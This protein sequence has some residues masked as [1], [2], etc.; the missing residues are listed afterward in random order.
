MSSKVRFTNKFFPSPR[1]L[2]HVSD[3]FGMDMPGCGSK[4]TR[5]DALHRHQKGICPVQKA[6]VARRITGVEGDSRLSNIE[7]ERAVAEVKQLDR[8]RQSA[9][10]SRVLIG[11]V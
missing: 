11:V 8:I 9:R 1:V 3:I 7:K 6:E 5:P 2:I 4:F 10:K